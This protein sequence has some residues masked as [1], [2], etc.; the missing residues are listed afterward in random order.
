MIGA[1]AV[2]VALIGVIASTLA[3][4]VADRAEAQ[5]YVPSAD[6]PD[7]STA[8]D[9][10]E[11]IEYPA[12][13]HVQAPQ[14]VAYDQSP[15]MGGPHDQYWA[16]CTG[17]IYPEPIRSENAVHSLEH[18]AVWITYD[19]QQV[20]GDEVPTLQAL[21]EGQPYTLLSP[22]PGLSSA[23]SVQSWGH[24]L[25]LDDSEDDRLD[26]FITA[27]RR[28]PNTHPEAGATCSTT[29]GSFDP[30]SP[31]PFDASPPGPDAVPMAV[32]GQPAP[33]AP[34]VGSNLQPRNG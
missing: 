12:G 4:K 3:P 21:V 20:A 9:G 16:T 26:Q 14:R 11:K 32:G 33:T 22:Y 29:P 6:N 23:I 30:S 13:T 18:G 19:P 31:P 8:I 27:L 1:A 7:P 34:A 24:R 15:P 17:T 5:Q 25:A 2:I 10:V 28:N